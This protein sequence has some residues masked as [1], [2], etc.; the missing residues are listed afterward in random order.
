MTTGDKDDP[1]E[2]QSADLPEKPYPEVHHIQN[3][4]PFDQG[5]EAASFG[6]P[7][8]PPATLNEY[9]EV[10]WLAGYDEHERG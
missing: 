6:H 5:K 8:E 9:E 1:A 10:E 2:P 4:S 3:N 7:R